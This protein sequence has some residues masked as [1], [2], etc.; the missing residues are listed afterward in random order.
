MEL[1]LS[2][3]AAPD[4]PR[5]IP[6][7]LLLI[8]G[9]VLLAARLS[10]GRL[11]PPG[12]LGYFWIFLLVCVVTDL[13]SFTPAVWLMAIVAFRALREYFSLVDLRLED[14]WG[15]LA[16]YLSIPFMIYL[17]QIDWYGFFIVSVPVYTFV[18][19]PFLVALGDERGRGSLLSMGAIDFGLF[20]FVYGLGHVA[21]LAFYSTW[22][23]LLLLLAM[24]ACNVASATTK[25]RGPAAGFVLSVM[26]TLALTL[27]LRDLTGVPT[28]HALVLGVLIP[29]LVR[30]GDYTVG[31]LKR[32]LGLDAGDLEPGRGHVLDSLRSC[33]FTAPIVFHYLRWALK[34]GELVGRDV[35]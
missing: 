28:V 18:V 19:V 17:I 24:T 21:Y 30:M 29:V 25:R 3:P 35:P 14:R 6:A 7:A 9:L 34:F 4:W 12:Y 8:S 27:G 10:R 32:D 16:A 33:L 23:V 22:L 20:C 13:V 5:I 2:T 15:I 26:L 11:S 1:A 31:V